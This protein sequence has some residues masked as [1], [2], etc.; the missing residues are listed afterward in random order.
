MPRSF[1]VKHVKRRY[2]KSK[3]KASTSGKLCTFGMYTDR[4][5]YFKVA[6]FYSM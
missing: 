5:Y 1:M 3:P 6:R 2:V 4:F